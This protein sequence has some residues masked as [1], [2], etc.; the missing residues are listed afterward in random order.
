[1]K[2]FVNI[3]CLYWVGK[4]RRRDFF[5]K[6][7]ERLYQSVEKHIDRPFEFYCLTNEENYKLPGYI[8]PIQL[9]YAWPGWWSKMEL[10]RSDLPE[11]RT[12]YMDL[13]SHVIRSLQPILDYEGDLVMFNTR[14]PEKKFKFLESRGWVCCYQAAT[15]LFDSGTACMV[16]IYD[17]FLQSPGKWMKQYRSD[18]DIMGAWIPDQPTF[19]N[20]WMIKLDT[21]RDYQQ[22]PDDCIIVT[23]Q[24]MDGLF[25]NTNSI[26]WFEQMAR[27]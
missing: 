1:M 24:T 18:Q 21:I 9:N 15:M 16:E 22:H 6:D 25:R 19:P 17:R 20:E 23:G 7:I 8:Q 14:I 3:L 27:G 4:F 13:D 2:E 10:H 11:G 5:T 26:P 12:L